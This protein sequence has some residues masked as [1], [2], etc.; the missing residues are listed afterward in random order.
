[1]REFL[2]AILSVISAESLTDIEFDSIEATTE[3]YDQASYDDL[4]RILDER[5]SISTLQDRLVAYYKVKGFD[6]EALDTAKSEIFIGS[7]LE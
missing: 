6:V 3:T 2:N 7:V 5:E 4:S 1:M